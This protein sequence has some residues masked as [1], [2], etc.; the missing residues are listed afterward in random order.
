KSTA[1]GIGGIGAA[2]LAG[3]G[4]MGAEAAEI[5]KRWDKAADVVVVGAGA[6]GL[7]AAI[8]AAQHGAAVIVIEQSLQTEDQQR[9]ACGNGDML[10]PIDRKRDGNAP[11]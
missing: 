7:A 2:A 9:V 11:Y 10:L 3:I 8:Q 4:A 1:V 6:A 5:P